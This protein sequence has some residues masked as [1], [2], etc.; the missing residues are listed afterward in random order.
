MSRLP[1]HALI[2]SREQSLYELY[3]QG[4]LE[5]RLSA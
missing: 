3:T 2:W 1:L 4:Q 5:Q